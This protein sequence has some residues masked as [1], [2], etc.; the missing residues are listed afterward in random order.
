MLDCFLGFAECAVQYNYVKPELNEDD[1]IEIVEGR[2]PVVE[3]ILPPGEKFTPNSCS[4]DNRKEPDNS[5]YRPEYGRKIGL[6][7]AGRA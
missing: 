7:K 2:H 6:F 5:A 3:R 1:K 4:L